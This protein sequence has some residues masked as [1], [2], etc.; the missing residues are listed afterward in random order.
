MTF[1]WDERKNEINKKK[2]DGLGFEDGVRVFLDPKRIEQF[3]A[4]HSE[5]EDRYTSIGLV[6]DVLFVVFTE[7]QEN[8]RIISVRKA[9]KKEKELYYENY[10]L[11]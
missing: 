11:R 3:D 4:S 9:T 6:G 8:I 10:D 2:H 7:R 5:N 1:E